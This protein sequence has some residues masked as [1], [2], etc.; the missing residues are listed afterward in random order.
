MTRKMRYHQQRASRSQLRSGCSYWITCKP[1]VRPRL[2]TTIGNSSNMILVRSSPR[3]SALLATR[4]LTMRNWFSLDCLPSVLV[5]LDFR[6]NNT[7]TKKSKPP[8]SIIRLISIRNMNV[9]T[10]KPVL[11]SLTTFTRRTKSTFSSQGSMSVLLWTSLM[12]SVCTDSGT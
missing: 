10:T 7:K 6:L 11:W 1:C 4:L 2:S 3:V 9:L 5:T 8:P 12:Q